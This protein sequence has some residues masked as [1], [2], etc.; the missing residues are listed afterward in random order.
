[1]TDKRLM[2]RQRMNVAHVAAVVSLAAAHLAL[3]P[4]SAHAADPAGCS[5]S[6]DRITCTNG[7]PEG[8][9][10]TGTSGDDTI[11]ITGTVYGTV[12]GG[13][14]NDTITVT[15]RDGA[16]GAYRNFAGFTGGKGETALGGGGE[17]LGG[18]GNDIITLT[19]GNGGRGGNASF[20]DGGDGGGAGAGIEGGVLDGGRGINQITVR[21]G[22]GGVGGTSQYDAGQSKSGGMGVNQGW[23][24]V[25]ADQHSSLVIEGGDGGDRG[26][27]TL[28]TEGGHALRA[29]TVVGGSAPEGV[30]IRLIGGD[31]GRGSRPSKGGYGVFVFGQLTGT[32]GDD[33]I[34]LEGGMSRNGGHRGAGLGSP[35]PV[36]LGDGN[37]TITIHKAGG[38]VNCGDGDDTYNHAG[39][40]GFPDRRTCEHINRL[41]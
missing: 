37:D 25:G 33:D 32:P 39:E 7:V 8:Q 28:P 12:D 21:G 31:T 41:Q 38:M 17:L 13:D 1:M 15:G 6:G 19:G 14:G 18:D 35:E 30:S 23:V 9:T 34:T 40:R 10:L 26:R 36:E 4:P 24:T 16:P 11:E 22:N 27:G 3:A 5:R 2:R 29:G 20:G